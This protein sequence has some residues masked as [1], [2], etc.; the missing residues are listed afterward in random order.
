MNKITE[1]IG[2]STEKGAAVNWKG[3]VKAQQCPYLGRKCLKNRKSQPEIAIGTCTVKHGVEPR[4][5]I[6]C[7]FRLLERKQ[8][9]TDCLHLLTLNEPGNEL[10][11]VTEVTIPGGSVDYFLVS[12]RHL[13]VRDFVGVEFQTL[14]TTGTVWPER[15]RFLHTVGVAVQ[16]ADVGSDRLFGMNWKMTAKT[17][18]VQLHHKVETFES[19]NKH[20]VLVV[21]DHLLAY[22]R[23]EF[24]FDHL[25]QARVGDPMHIHAYS[26]Q[27]AGI[28]YKIALKERASTDAAGIARCLGLQASPN[29]DLQQIVQT[30]ESKLSADT[31]LTL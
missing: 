17:I 20:L 4:D 31:L 3:L 12:A 19:I 8:V 2:V 16:K 21:Q 23:R 14:D 10:H 18:L 24:A 11:V 28:D 1:L 30:L 6:I 27:P 13:R 5:I 22:M 25:E 9:F 29:V 26:L 7:P 15:Q